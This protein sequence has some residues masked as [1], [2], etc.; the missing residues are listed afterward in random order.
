[1]FCQF[2]LDTNSECRKILTE[3]VRAARNFRP[4]RAAAGAERAGNPRGHTQR[5]EH[6]V[7][8]EAARPHAAAL[9]KKSRRIRITFRLDQIS[10]T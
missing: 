9:K 2:R 7:P 5:T 1:M 6:D 8:H 4:R 10:Q 3:T